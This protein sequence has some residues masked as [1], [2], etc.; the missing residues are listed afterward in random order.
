MKIRLRCCNCGERS[1]AVIPC[2]EN[3]EALVQ[4][5]W[6][7]S[8]LTH[9]YCDECSTKVTGK[10]TGITTPHP[11]SSMLLI[12]QIMLDEY[13]KQCD[14]VPIDQMYPPEDDF[15]LAYQRKKDQG[16]I[17]GRVKYAA[18]CMPKGCGLVFYDPMTREQIHGITHWR[19][20]PYPPD[21][22]EINDGW[23]VGE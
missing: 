10:E 7:V 20:K 1:E 12:M 19:P 13:K 21:E 17:C 5:G 15:F 6:G 9:V 2:V 4:D 18:C 23:L 16:I 11:V 22:D 8:D 3:A 14:W